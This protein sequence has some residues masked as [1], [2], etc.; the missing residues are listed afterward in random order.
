MGLYHRIGETVKGI[1]TEVAGQFESA[2]FRGGSSRKQAQF[3]RGSSSRTINYDVGEPSLR[4]KSGYAQDD[5]IVRNNLSY[6]S[7]DSAIS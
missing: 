6:S 3:S 7:D 2:S 4:L 5:A 1:D